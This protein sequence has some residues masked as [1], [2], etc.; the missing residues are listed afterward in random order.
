MNRKK[1]VLVEYAVLGLLL[2]KAMTIYELNRAFKQGMSLFYS[3]SYGSLQTAVKKLLEKGYAAYTESVE[4]G[5]HKK[6]FSITEEGV[7]AFYDWMQE[8]IPMSKLEV[9]ALSKLHFLGLVS[10]LNERKKVVDRIMTAI[11]AMISELEGYEKEIKAYQIPESYQTIFFYQ[12]KTLDY[13]IMAH[14]AALEWFKML[15][16]KM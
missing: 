11:E 13:G 6:I 3:A 2:I 7:K 14:K 15:L 5:R 9:T 16:P 8:D 4:N 1:V 12:A 10:D